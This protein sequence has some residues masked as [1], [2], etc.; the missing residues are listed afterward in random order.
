MASNAEHVSTW[1]RHDLQNIRDT[2]WVWLWCYWNGNHR[3]NIYICIY[4]YIVRNKLLWLKATIL[5]HGLDLAHE[6]RTK[7]GLPYNSWSAL[8]TDYLDMGN[9]THTQTAL[10]PEIAVSYFPSDYSRS[11][12]NFDNFDT[13]SFWDSC[14]IYQFFE[15][16]G[17]WFAWW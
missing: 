9:E 17:L 4:I 7:K 15:K 14:E 10:S 12:L 2:L 13:R 8:E 16:D 6:S 11:L 5:A 3:S 1:C